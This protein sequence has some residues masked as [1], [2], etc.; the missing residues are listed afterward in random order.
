MKPPFVSAADILAVTAA[1]SAM[2][3]SCAVRIAA[4]SGIDIRHYARKGRAGTQKRARGSITV[5]ERIETSCA[6]VSPC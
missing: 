1:K 5:A 3:Q 6:L 4:M 2:E